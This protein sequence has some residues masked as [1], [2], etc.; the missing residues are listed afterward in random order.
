VNK[1]CV[2]A[3][4]AANV[5]FNVLIDLLTRLFQSDMN[6]F[7]PVHVDS[8]VNRLWGWLF[9]HADPTVAAFVSTRGVGKWSCIAHV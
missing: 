9:R 6:A 2:H 5:K 3:K 8:S 4:I 1:L 7:F